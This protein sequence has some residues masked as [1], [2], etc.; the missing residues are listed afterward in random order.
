M[1]EPRTAGGEGN[2][3]DA[4][5]RERTAG[6]SEHRP[7]IDWTAAE[8]SPEFREL[9]RKRRAFVLPAT[10]FFLV[11]YFGFIIL[12]GYAPGFMRQ[13]VYQGLTIGYLLALSQFVMTWVLAYVYIRKS[14]R[15]F[16]PLARRAADRARGSSEAGAAD[17][18]VT[19]R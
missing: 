2:G 11:W 6:G 19:A 9:I 12:A 5:A 4:A 15:D 3:A 10:I 13:S 18:E 8:Q 1:S 14:D 17:R 7:G 16:D